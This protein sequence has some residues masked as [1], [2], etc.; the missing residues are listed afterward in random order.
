MAV[1]PAPL[2]DV[3]GRPWRPP[4]PPAERGLEPAPLSAAD[5]HG[6]VSLL[7]VADDRP[8]VLLLD[9]WTAADAP[10]E[11]AVRDLLKRPAEAPG[12][13]VV[14]ALDASDPVRGEAKTRFGGRAGGP[15]ATFTNS[16][17][18]T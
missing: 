7:T 13:R 16:D 8:V 14:V 2:L 17:A 6:L 10:A 12:C 9:G 5:L 18:W 15:A 1:L 3:P 11:V 4:P